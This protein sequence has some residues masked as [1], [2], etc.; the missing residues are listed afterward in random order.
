[1]IILFFKELFN[2]VH[3]CTIFMGAYYSLFEG[4]ETTPNM[5]KLIHITNLFYLFKVQLRN[6]ILNS[7]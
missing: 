5:M 4:Y 7:I 1:M 6:L 3:M 2:V